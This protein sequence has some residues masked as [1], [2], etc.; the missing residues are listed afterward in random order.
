MPAEGD[1]KRLIIAREDG[2]LLVHV[3]VDEA[4]FE[5]L[6]LVSV[7]RGDDVNVFATGGLLFLSVG[8]KEIPLREVVAPA[9]VAPLFAFEYAYTQQVSAGVDTDGVFSQLL[10]WHPPQVDLPRREST[11]DPKPGPSGGEAGA[12]PEPDVPE[13]LAESDD[14]LYGRGT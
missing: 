9:Q 12:Q 3:R 7:E 13:W 1:V 14:P 6:S 10:S 2:P 4:P 5:P 11:S 8:A